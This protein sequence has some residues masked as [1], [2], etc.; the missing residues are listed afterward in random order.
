M[1]LVA[2]STSRQN[3]DLHV[4]SRFLDSNDWCCIRYDVLPF[5]HLLAT[6][7]CLFLWSLRT[8]YIA[9]QPAYRNPIPTKGKTYTPGFTRVATKVNE[10][11]APGNRDH[12][13]RIK[14]SDRLWERAPAYSSYTSVQ[15][16]PNAIHSG[17]GSVAWRSFLSAC[18][19][20][21]QI[22]DVAALQESVPSPQ[23]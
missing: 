4:A 23:I 17:G 14:R 20:G 16:Y 6:S 19:R 18:G 2:R 8:W 7:T 11:E 15:G 12:R 5:F 21:D 3:F 10:H 13:L 22:V 9:Y 1:C